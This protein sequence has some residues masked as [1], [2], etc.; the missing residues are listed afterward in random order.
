MVRNLV[1][2]LILPTDGLLVVQPRYDM[3]L[4][5]APWFY[6]QNCAV[7]EIVS[8]PFKYMVLH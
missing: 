8:F 5:M 4:A 7:V 1:G 3:E 6:K 2:D